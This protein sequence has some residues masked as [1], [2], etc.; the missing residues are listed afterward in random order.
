MKTQV[1]AHVQI[2]KILVLF[3]ETLEENE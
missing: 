2:N 1:I 3:K